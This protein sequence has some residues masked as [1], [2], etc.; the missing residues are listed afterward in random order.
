MR[1]FQYPVLETSNLSYL[2]EWEGEILSR[3]ASC[4]ERIVGE[5]TWD[6]G[7]DWVS[8]FTQNISSSDKD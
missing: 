6:G 3:V 5:E 8:W 7:M 1:K 2:Q 4:L